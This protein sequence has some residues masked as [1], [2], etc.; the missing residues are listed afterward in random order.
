MN[1]KYLSFFV[2]FFFF[3]FTVNAEEKKWKFIVV[4]NTDFIFYIITLI[5]FECKI[6]GN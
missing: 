1:L 3:F 4:I 5:A 6:R 2:M